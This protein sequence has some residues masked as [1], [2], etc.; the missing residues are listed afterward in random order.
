M[1][2]RGELPGRGKDKGAGGGPG[3]AAV[4]ACRGRGAGEEE[5][6]QTRDHKGESLPAPG[7]GASLRKFHRYS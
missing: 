2:L 3:P 4:I 7:L 5:V 1:D 6:L